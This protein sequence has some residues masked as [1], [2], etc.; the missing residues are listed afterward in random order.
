MPNQSCRR[1][2]AT[3]FQGADLV[4]GLSIQRRQ[5]TVQQA[6]SIGFDP[7][8]HSFG[9]VKCGRTDRLQFAGR[10]PRMWLEFGLL[11]AAP[12]GLSGVCDGGAEALQ[13]QCAPDRAITD[14]E[15]RRAPD[16]EGV[17]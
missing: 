6:G 14:D 7:A 1:L 9:F 11:D 15:G 13:R 2:P 12:Q 17:G 10:K 3:A 8:T 16:A 4:V 5:A